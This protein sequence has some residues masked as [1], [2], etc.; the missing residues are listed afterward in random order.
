MRHGSGQAAAGRRQWPRVRPV[1]RRRQRLRAGGCFWSRQK[2]GC[3]RDEPGAPPPQPQPPCTVMCACHASSIGPLTPSTARC[4]GARRSSSHRSVM[5][6]TPGGGGG[7]APPPPPP[8][9]L[10]PRGG[11]G[12]GGG[13]G[14][15]ACA[16]A[17]ACSPCSTCEGTQVCCMR[18]GVCRE[19]KKHATTTTSSLIPQA[20]QAVKDPPSRSLRTSLDLV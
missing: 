10:P 13:G 15:L 8:P 20:L 11:G 12:G 4:S 2:A 3:R 19:M 1:V 16:Y 5:N 7:R 14:R 6:C 9:P 18:A 17:L